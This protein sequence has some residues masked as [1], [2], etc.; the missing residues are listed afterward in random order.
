MSTH[1]IEPTNSACPAVGAPSGCSR[2]RRRRIDR[3]AA[4]LR[5]TAVSIDDPDVIQL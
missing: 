3:G 2:R 1:P 5:R 4:Q